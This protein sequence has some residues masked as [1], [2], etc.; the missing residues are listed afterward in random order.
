MQS[1][2]GELELPAHIYYDQL[3]EAM[4]LHAFRL[5][6]TYHDV[7]VPPALSMAAV[8]DIVEM[9]ALHVLPGQYQDTL[10]VSGAITT[11]ADDLGASGTGHGAAVSTFAA[12]F[13]Q[14]QSQPASSCG[15]GMMGTT[16][17][18]T[19]SPPLAAASFLGS[20]V[21]DLTSDTEELNLE[22]SEATM[23]PPSRS[24]VAG[25]TNSFGLT[26][27]MNLNEMDGSIFC[28][29]GSMGCATAAGEEEAAPAQFSEKSSDTD[30]VDVLEPGQAQALED[31]AERSA[32]PAQPYHE[33]KVADLKAALRE[34]G[35]PIS[36]RKPDL[37]AR[38]EAAGEE[39]PSPAQF[40]EKS[41]D[42][43]DVDVL[44]PGQVSLSNLRVGQ[45]LRGMVRRISQWGAF[46]EIGPGAT[47]LARISRMAERFLEDVF[48]VV[49]VGEEVI[50][51]VYRIAPDGKIGLSMIEYPPSK[52]KDPVS[53][54]EDA[55]PSEWFTAT[56]RFISNWSIFVDVAVPEGG[57]LVQGILHKSQFPYPEK[58]A[59]G[60]EVQVRVVEI[61]S[62]TGT[63][64]LTAM[65]RGS[66]AR[67]GEL[68][69]PHRSHPVD[70]EAMAGVCGRTLA[71]VLLLAAV[72]ARLMQ[73][74]HSPA[75]LEKA[76]ASDLDT[77][78]L[79][80]LSEPEKADDKKATDSKEDTKV[81]KKEESEKQDD[82]KE[83]DKK[84]TKEVSTK[85][86]GKK[87]EDKKEV[88]K[89][90]TDKKDDDKKDQDKKEVDKKEEDK[91]ADVKKDEDKKD[92]DTKE[93]DKK[94]VDKKDED[95]K[96]DIKKDEDKKEDDKKGDDKKE[97]D[98]KEKELE[99]EVEKEMEKEEAQDDKKGKKKDEKEDEKVDVT[100]VVDDKDDEKP[101]SKSEIHDPYDQGKTKIVPEEVKKEE[102]VTG[103]EVTVH[104]KGALPDDEKV[105]VTVV[106]NETKGS[107][108]TEPNKPEVSVDVHTKEVV[109]SDV[110]TTTTEEAKNEEE[111]SS[112]GR[113][114]LSLALGVLGFAVVATGPTVC[115][116]A[117]DTLVKYKSSWQIAQMKKLLT[118]SPLHREQ[119]DQVVQHFDM[120]DPV[121]VADLAAGIS[122][123]DRKALQDVLEEQDAKIKIEKVRSIL[124]ADLSTAKL[125]SEVKSKVEE[126]VAKEQKTKILWEQM[127]Q[128]Q[129]ELGIEKDCNGERGGSG[130]R[131]VSSLCF[132][133]EREEVPED[134]Q[135]VIDAELAKLNSLEPS[136]SEFN[137]CR[138]YLE[139]LTCLPWG[140]FTPENRDIKHAETVL[141]ED[142]YGLEDVKER[143]LEHIAVSFLKDPCSNGPTAWPAKA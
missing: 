125:Q 103:P 139:W 26:Q 113:A 121:Q 77:L 17:A 111:R 16:G 140:V 15:P 118:A 33:M 124:E 58:A 95:K 72:Q 136:S 131:M 63:L 85:E 114:V 52:L 76:S 44:E 14:T 20:G 1:E 59:K 108:A 18:D 65:R 7:S 120:E 37:V 130:F 74:P 79:E 25:G 100:V 99:K 87:E 36:G 31:E 56:V 104:N 98:K 83:E 35:M 141:D 68:Q 38:L 86:E 19:S 106:V 122:S 3:E 42:T 94:E 92:D 82:K 53:F 9:M 91:K 126:K 97:D 55:R 129:K 89:K 12:G 51:W 112:S 90:A 109:V 30:D 96:A 34:L 142:H 119:H 123:G 61:I 39:E 101:S 5:M 54:F 143:I 137:V 80:V 6:A 81:A 115:G 43:D 10:N 71:V 84:E 107:T 2:C 138:T 64:R 134:V 128:I 45:K 49:S 133:H 27:N 117:L 11:I 88:D 32:G 135:K 28:I 75:L 47:A 23:L 116:A 105:D 110:K 67:T 132:G 70:A 22:A 78:Q 102:T 4:L 13:T 73:K 29:V 50:V 41:S 60:Q 127:R 40:F 57:G 48:D 24:N 21:I 69:P 66:R 93:E 62:N 8:N 46:I